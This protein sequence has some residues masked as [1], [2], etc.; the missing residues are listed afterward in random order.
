MLKRLN[1]VHIADKEL[2]ASGAVLKSK[3]YR[4][5][6]K[7]ILGFIAV[8]IMNFVYSYFFYT[9]KLYS[10][11]QQGN[12]LVVK[13]QILRS[14]IESASKEVAV[15]DERRRNVYSAVLGIDTAMM[16]QR[17]LVSYGHDSLYG[18]NRYS[19]LIKDAWGGIDLLTASLYHQS[20]LLDTVQ[21]L[22][23][24]KEAMLASLPSIWP[25][26]ED[27]FRRISDPYG[28]RFHPIRKYW[29]FHTGIDLAAH[30]NAPIYVTADG[31]VESAGWVSGYG[32]TVVVNHGYGYKTRYAHASKIKVSRGDTVSRGT[33][34][35][36]VGST[37][38]SSGNH[39]HYEVIY[40]NM[41]T[42]PISYFGRDMSDEDFYAIINEAN[43][44][45]HEGDEI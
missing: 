32:N 43:K 21:M 11:T 14:N 19:P 4:V 22:S 12:E 20:V 10:L 34:I 29:H 16:S 30:K 37:G 36:T 17:P 18:E 9:P 39:L 24:D 41:H 28:R 25:L 15:V 26:D 2:V 23:S 40:R 6:C 31:V 7:L 44:I 45:E 13:M 8:S 38:T 5:V 3:I 27:G 42:N 1:N 35:A 33:I